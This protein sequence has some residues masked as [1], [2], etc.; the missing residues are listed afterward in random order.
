[1]KEI[2]RQ[3]MQELLNHNILAKI[4]NLKSK[5]RLSRLKTKVQWFVFSNKQ[6]DKKLGMLL[7]KQNQREKFKIQVCM[8]V[9][10]TLI[11]R[12]IRAWMDRLFLPF[13]MIIDQV[14]RIIRFHQLSVK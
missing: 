7:W 12:G 13:T 5:I 3:I 10:I 4:K 2:R 6:E 14:L 1:M 9:V 11:I 8:S